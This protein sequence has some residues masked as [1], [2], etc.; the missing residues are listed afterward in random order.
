M[1]RCI[2]HALLQAVPSIDGIELVVQ[3]SVAFQEED[4]EID[5]HCKHARYTLKSNVLVVL[6][7]FLE[8]VNINDFFD[9]ITCGWAGC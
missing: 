6:C 4:G 5:H 7:G 1:A 9:E 3:P 8:R 2:L